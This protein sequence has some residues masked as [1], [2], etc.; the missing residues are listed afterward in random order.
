MPSDDV[1]SYEIAVEQ[2]VY[3]REL[4][5]TQAEMLASVGVSAPP[6]AIRLDAETVVRFLARAHRAMVALKRRAA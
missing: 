3:W 2:Y 5:L 4:G 1:D 6:A